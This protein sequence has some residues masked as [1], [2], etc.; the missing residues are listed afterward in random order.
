MEAGAERA[1]VGRKIVEKTDVVT[2]TLNA[3]QQTE[4]KRT[5]ADIM[6]SKPIKV[7]K[8]SCNVCTSFS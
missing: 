7:A 4:D 2:A 6:H 8:I 1:A 3:L 5:A